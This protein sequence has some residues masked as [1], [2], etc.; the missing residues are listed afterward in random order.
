MLRR[1]ILFVLLA[2]LIGLATI[3]AWIPAFIY[4]PTLLTRPDPAAWGLPSARV[5]TILSGP[6]DR[7]FAWGAT[8]QYIGAG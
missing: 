3:S 4:R 8:A 7:L 6:S 5:V 2:A 1:L